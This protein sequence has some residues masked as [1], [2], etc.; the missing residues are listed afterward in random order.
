MFHSLR[1][2][3]AACALLACSM[4]I[5]GC[6][7]ASNVTVIGT[8]LRGDKPIPVSK[9]GNIMVTLKPDVVEDAQFTTYVGYC[10]PANGQF[11]IPAVPPGDYIVGIEQWDPNPMSDKLQGKF[12]YANSKFK[13]KIDGKAPLTI[14]LAKPE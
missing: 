3:A 7:P 14:D 6:G 10:D 9:T 11:E 5:C 8:V 13:R 12:S 4:F 2:Q 1:S